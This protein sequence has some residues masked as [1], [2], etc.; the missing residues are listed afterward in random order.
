MAI[1]DIE[2]MISNL[3]PEALSITLNLLGIDAKIERN[4]PV[5][6][7][8]K[9][10]GVYSGNFTPELEEP[11]KRTVRIILT[12][13]YGFVVGTN[14]ERGT[15]EGATCYTLDDVLPGDILSIKRTTGEIRKYK[16]LHPEILGMTQTVL[17]RFILSSITH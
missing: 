17:K 16:V 10:Y 6:L 15:F 13:G 5:E 2:T 7:P 14:V 9:I 11:K 4:S 8:N 1:S 3:L 12:T